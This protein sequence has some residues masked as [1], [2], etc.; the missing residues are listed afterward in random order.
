MGQTVKIGSRSSILAVKQSEI[1]IK[2]AKEAN[3]G[4]DFEL[5]TMETTG[6]KILGR[7]LADIG[8]K[9]LFTAEL[10][11]ALL[12]GDIDISVSSLKDL[13]SPLEAE[14]P[15][16][17]HS[18]RADPFDCLVLPEGG[19]LDLSLP[20]GTS[21]LRR[22]AQIRL[23]WPEAVFKAVRGN[24]QT[25][26]RKLNEEGYSALVFAY[27]G[28][29]RLGLENIAWKKFT[30][31]EM[32]PSAGQGIIAAQSR[33]GFDV[34]FLESS[35]DFSSRCAAIAERAFVEAM[36]LGCASPIAAYAELDGNEVFLR[37]MAEIDGNCRFAELRSQTDQ[38]RDL[39]YRV[40]E[41][42]QKGSAL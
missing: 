24:V 9:G 30:P 10:D 8:G 26:L 21:S 6:D 33:K 32:L 11:R 28:L 14:L 4:I 20:I 18:K 19:Q 34:S 23:M 29:E 35:N 2:A 42:I 16:V 40:C 27:A 39:G 5:I 3:P 13:P 25:R 41:L 7:N 15:I 1:F 12:N 36:G 31:S 37:A 38:A 22:I 17:W